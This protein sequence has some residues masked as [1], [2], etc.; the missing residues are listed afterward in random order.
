MMTERKKGI[1]SEQARRVLHE[2]YL[3]KDDAGKVYE[4]GDG[5]AWR[6]AAA[7]ASAE[8]RFPTAGR[9]VLRTA[10]E[11]YEIMV[12]QKFLPNSPTLMNAGTGNGHQLSACYVLPVEDSLEGIFDAVK[13]QALVHAS[14]GG[15]GFSFSRLRPNGSGV[16]TTQGV[17][18]GPVSF[19]KVF[20]AATEQIKQ[21]GKRRGANMGILRIDHPDILEFIDCKLEGGITNFNISCGVTDKFMAA[22]ANDEEYDL[23]APHNGEVTGRLRARDVFAKIVDA[24]WR[25]GDPGLV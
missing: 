5:M 3:M 14:G 6:V 24:A 9:S 18:S 7:V 16:K 15:T 12:D 10:E 20:D 17:A 2:R 19:M 4:D 1:W 11:F 13:W 23:V 21:G 22:L 25:S 8:D